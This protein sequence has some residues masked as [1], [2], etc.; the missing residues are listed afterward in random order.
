MA[1]RLVVS[2]EALILGASHGQSSGVARA[3]RDLVD[4]HGTMPVVI[5]ATSHKGEMYVEADIDDRAVVL[6]RVRFTSAVPGC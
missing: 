1:K 3:L 6:D 2:P 5:A 4:R